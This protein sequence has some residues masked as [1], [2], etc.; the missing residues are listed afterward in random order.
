MI[1]LSGFTSDQTLGPYLRGQLLLNRID[2]HRPVGEWL[3]AVY[4]LWVGAPHEIVKKAHE[5]IER[6]SVTIEPDRDT[7]GELP[8]H[9]EAMRDLT[10][11]T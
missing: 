3:D 9:I 5:I 4:A 8:E 2:L 6:H 1:L 7:W 10:D 11:L